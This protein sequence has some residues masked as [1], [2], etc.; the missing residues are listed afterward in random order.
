VRGRRSARQPCENRRDFTAH[1]FACA[2][3]DLVV[4]G[5]GIGIALNAWDIYNCGHLKRVWRASLGSISG[6]EPA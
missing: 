4:L 3:I 2:L 6:G 5:W 1:L